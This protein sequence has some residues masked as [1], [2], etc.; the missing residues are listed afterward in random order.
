MAPRAVPALVC[1]LLA[2]GVIFAGC[3]DDGGSTTAAPTA[4]ATATFDV[5]STA[6]S[7]EDGAEPIFW[8]T[9][10]AFASLRA[11][12]E[13]KV[14]FRITSG[15]AEPALAITATRDDFTEEASFEANRVEP[16]GGEAAGSYYPVTII[17]PSPGAWTITVTAAAA[18]ASIPVQVAP[19]AG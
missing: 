16:V 18:E 3:G 13:Y 19:A 10:D 17:L 7:S 5:S 14:L 8:R 1:A 2:L 11:G 4:P 9:Q 12:V 6:I 15:Y